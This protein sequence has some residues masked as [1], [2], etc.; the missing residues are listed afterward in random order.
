RG[1]VP[2]GNDDEYNGRFWTEYVLGEKDN[3]EG[4]RAEKR[5]VFEGY[6]EGSLGDKR[7]D[8][9][10]L[11]MVNALR[12][13]LRGRASR[14]G[15]PLREKT[16]ANI[17][18]VLATAL[19]YA[20]AAGVIDRMPPIRIRAVAPP[21]IECWTFDEYGRLLGAAMHEGEPWATAV[22]LAGEAGLRIGE[23]IAL[24]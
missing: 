1:T 4:T 15:G 13:E 2:K 9:I 12:A 23:V 3:R 18:G 5:K 6:L 22:L 21:P 11:G 14:R 19:R 24:E 20:E 10:D 17:L 16:R 8:A 7:L